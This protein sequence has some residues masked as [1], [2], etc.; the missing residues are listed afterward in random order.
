MHAAIPTTYKGINFRSRLEARWAAFFDLLGWRWEYEPEDLAGWIPDFVL[1]EMERF[2]SILVEVKPIRDMDITAKAAVEKYYR[3]G[4]RRSCLIL[5]T[6]PML[7]VYGCTLGYFVDAPLP[8]PFHDEDCPTPK[9]HQVKSVETIYLYPQDYFGDVGL[10]FESPMCGD[11]DADLDTDLRTKW[12]NAG[13][14]MQWHGRC[15]RP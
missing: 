9:K 15:M 10:S 8:C 7:S 3:S 12:N 13:N 4:D 1:L 6:G 14:I 2:K 5:G 11:P